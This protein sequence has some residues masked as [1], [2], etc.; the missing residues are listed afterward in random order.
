MQ[1]SDSLQIHVMGKVGVA[2]ERD[3][4][5]FLTSR[6]STVSKVSTAAN[7]FVVKI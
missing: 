4:W 2:E 1:L 5:D 7:S 6:D 3:P